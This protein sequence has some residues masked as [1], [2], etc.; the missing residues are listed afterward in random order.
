MVYTLHFEDTEVESATR[1]RKGDDVSPTLTVLRRPSGSVMVGR[2]LISLALTG[3]DLLFHCRPLR[4]EDLGV[5]PF[6]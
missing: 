6:A 2:G 5:V 4:S 1:K 3:A